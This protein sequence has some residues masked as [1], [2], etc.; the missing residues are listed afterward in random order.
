MNQIDVTITK[1]RRVQAEPMRRPLHLGF[2]VEYRVIYAGWGPAPAK[3]LANVR[4]LIGEPAEVLYQ[5]IAGHPF[6]EPA[7]AADP[8]QAID[9]RAQA[10]ADLRLN[11]K[12]V[13]LALRVLA[14]Y[15]DHLQPGLGQ[16][17]LDRQGRLRL[18]APATIELP[19]LAL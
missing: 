4:Y 17:Q 6:D 13:S 11:S 3:S 1:T 14:H 5:A 16:V 7:S 2:D 9:A 10:F 8:E 12:L 18:N 15:E 19:E